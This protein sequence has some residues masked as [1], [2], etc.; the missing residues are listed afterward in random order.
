MVSRPIERWGVAGVAHT[1][2]KDLLPYCPAN[3]T[4]SLCTLCGRAQSHAPGRCQGRARVRLFSH[5]SLITSRE[6]VTKYELQPS[7][8]ARKHFASYDNLYQMA[9]AVLVKATTL[10]RRARERNQL[11]AFCSFSFFSAA[12]PG[13]FLIAE[14]YKDANYA[15]QYKDLQFFFLL[16]EDG[17]ARLAVEVTIRNLKCHKEKQSE[18]RKV[19]SV[20]RDDFFPALDPAILLFSMAMEDGALEGI[21][22]QHLDGDGL[23]ALNF[24]EISHRLQL[25]PVKTSMLE[26][27][28]FSKIKGRQASG[29]PLTADGMRYQ[30]NKSRCLASPTLVA[31]DFR[32]RAVLLLNR[33]DITSE[34]SRSGFRHTATNQAM[35][36]ALPF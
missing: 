12:R 36:K 30:F 5:R 22:T 35:G 33:P 28:V 21:S 2:D 13:D 10:M 18:W 11:L 34:D 14:D 29:E 19:S 25:G 16:C 23:V 1:K 6:N 26:V 24:T 31:Y 3:C 32:R 17:V 4:E 20:S 15:L 9:E 8:D 7:K 27:R